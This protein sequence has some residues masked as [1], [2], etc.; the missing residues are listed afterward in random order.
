MKV[1]L[2]QHYLHSHVLTFTFK[3]YVKIIFLTKIKNKTVL[4]ANTTFS[5][6][7]NLTQQH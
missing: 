7:I 3:I 1:Q 6:Q 2:M 4:T 5:L